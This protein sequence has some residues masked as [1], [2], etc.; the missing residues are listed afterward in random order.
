MDK[1]RR[2]LL[3]ATTV[4]IG[5]IGAVVTSIPFIKAM[6]PSERTKIAGSSVTVDLKNLELGKQET[7]KWRGK[8]VWILRRTSQMLTDLEKLEP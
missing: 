8:P 6:L 2:K 4:G 5:G 1:S 3:T 7:I